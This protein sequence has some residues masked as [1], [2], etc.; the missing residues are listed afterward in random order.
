M[1]V[2]SSA[3][4][5]APAGSGTISPSTAT[6]R[7]KSDLAARTP[8]PTHVRIGA[9]AAVQL[10]APRAR[11]RPSARPAARRRQPGH[12]RAALRRHPAR[13]RPCRRCAGWLPGRPGL[14]PPVVG[15]D[16]DP[17]ASQPGG[18]TDILPFLADG[19]RQLVVGDDDLRDPGLQVDTSHLDTRAG[20]SAWA[21]NSAGSSRVVDD[22]DLL[23]VQLGHHVADPAAHRA[24]ARALGVHAWLMEMTAILRPVPGLA[25]DRRD[26][27]RAGG[28]L[29]H[30]ERE[31]LPHQ[32]GVGP[33]QCH[34]WPAEALA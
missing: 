9:T 27:D 22:V 34:R 1:Q 13:P 20:D 4:H 7:S 25:G 10:T 14:L 32:V 17:P 19:Q 11:H 12:A 3:W 29:R 28:N 24:D 31:Q 23:A 33:R 8:H 15:L 30:L 16:V 18:E 6:T 5:A 26:L 2:R 21:T